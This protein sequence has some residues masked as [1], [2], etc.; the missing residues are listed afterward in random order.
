MISK[1]VLRSPNTHD[2][3]EYNEEVLDF[4]EEPFLPALREFQDV[5]SSYCHERDEYCKDL[6]TIKTSVEKELIE[7]FADL[8]IVIKFRL[9]SSYPYMYL[10]DHSDIDFAILLQPLTE[11]LRKICIDR[12]KNKG[13]KCNGLIY[14]YTSCVKII[15]G[16]EIEVKIRD[17]NKSLHIIA[18]HEYL[19]NLPSDVQQLL[20]WAK[21]TTKD[22][23]SVYNRLKSIIY[24]AFYTKINK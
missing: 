9:M 21:F 19:E 16:I 11:K 2:P 14:G 17:L 18:L 10:K 13:Y 20:T 24:T 3:I 23:P 8:S 4:F 15:N 6:S 7:L 5:A 12:L 22:D 1:L